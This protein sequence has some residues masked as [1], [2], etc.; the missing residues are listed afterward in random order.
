MF[1]A[2]SFVICRILG[3]RPRPP[4]QKHLEWPCQFGS[5]A[6]LPQPILHVAWWLSHSMAQLKTWQVDATGVYGCIRMYANRCLE[7]DQF[8]KGF[9]GRL[10]CNLDCTIY[11]DVDVIGC[12]HMLS[13]IPVALHVLLSVCCLSLESHTF[14]HN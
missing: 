6:G 3:T 13:N 10:H 2:F 9:Y 7:A 4:G 14:K 1:H 11:V 5:L 8:L 12:Y